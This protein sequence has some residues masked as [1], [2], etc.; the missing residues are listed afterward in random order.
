MS[1][2]EKVLNQLTSLIDQGNRFV[3]SG[4][5]P[6]PISYTKKYERA[7]QPGGLL[8]QINEFEIPPE[9]EDARREILSKFGCLSSMVSKNV[10]PGSFLNQIAEVKD[11]LQL[12][13]ESLGVEIS[14]KNKG[15]LL[16]RLVGIKSQLRELTSQ[17]ISIT[18][19]FSVTLS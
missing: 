2:F 12:L 5:Q 10:S 13:T 11:Q 18:L 17:K 16:Q 3:L 14:E 1:T 8:E 9:E 19:Q 15:N 7:L 4:I 6:I